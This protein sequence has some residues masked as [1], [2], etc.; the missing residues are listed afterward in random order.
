MKNYLMCLVLLGLS[1]AMYS[2]E[3]ITYDVELQYIHELETDSIFFS[4]K[5]SKISMTI[6]NDSIVTETDGYK[7]TE[8]VIETKTEEGNTTYTLKNPLLGLIWLTIEDNII[9]IKF[10]IDPKMLYC[11]KTRV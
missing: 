2:Q 1:L 7:T 9:K 6:Y 5:K 4:E 8:L 11:Y 3:P 10:D